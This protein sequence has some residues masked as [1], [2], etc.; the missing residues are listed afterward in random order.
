M[1]DKQMIDKKG[2]M[3]KI[4]GMFSNRRPDDYIKM[5]DDYFEALPSA[6]ELIAENERLN[7]EVERLKDIM[8]ESLRDCCTDICKKEAGDER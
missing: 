2:F 3:S 8:S 7:A 6:D 1:S 4:N 5:C